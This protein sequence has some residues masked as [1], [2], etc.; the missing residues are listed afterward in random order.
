[1][2]TAFITGITGQDGSYLTELL[3][4]KGYSVHGLVRRPESL[5]SGNLRHLI[6]DPAVMDRRLFLHAGSFEDTT[7]LR[8]ILL[9]ARP[10]EFYHLAGGTSPRASLELPEAAVESV[11]MATL[12]ILEILRDFPDPPRF[13]LASSSEVF[14]SA[15]QSP[16]DEGTP[17]DPNTPYGAAKATAQ[18]LVR[19]YRTAYRLPMCSAIL[20]NHESPRRLDTFV[21]MKVARAAARIRAGLQQRLVLGRL[22]GRRDWGW[23]PD[24][25]QGMWQMLQ[26]TH[27]EDFILATGTLHSVRD[28][29]ETAFNEV[30]LDWTRH[31]DYD[32]HLV[33]PVEP[34]APCGNPGRAAERLGWRNTVEFPDLV[35]RLV[36]S[37]QE[38]LA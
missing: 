26:Q 5:S 17:M 8:R 10:D 22:D 28:F 15:R 16:Q 20:Y 1:M 30:G 37:Q 35:R 24:Y 36:R 27:L 25:V 14:G 31:V 33:Q 3:L 21:T 38:A 4:G 12:R 34:V 9:R 6:H 29:V 13:L 7:Y 23:A 2:P 32:P 19:I 11:G 18:H